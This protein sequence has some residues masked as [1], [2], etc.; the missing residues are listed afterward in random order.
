MSIYEERN[1]TRENEHEVLGCPWKTRLDGE[2][3][4]QHL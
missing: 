4:F 2:P 1:L 3:F